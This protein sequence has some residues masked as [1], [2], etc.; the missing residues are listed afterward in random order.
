M[1]ASPD[2]AGTTVA[3]ATLSE[4]DDPVAFRFGLLA[5]IQYTDV[6]DRCNHTGTQ[7]RRYR[8]SLAVARNAVDYFNQSELSFVLHNGDIIDHQCA[9][10]FAKDEFK[11]KAEGIEQLAS[12]MRILSGSLCKDWMFTIGN[13]ELYNFTAA[14]LRDGVT[15]EGCDLPFKCANDEGSFFFSRTPAPGWRVIVL[16]SYDVSIY[17][18]GREQGLDVDALELLRKHNV[19]VDKW[20]TDNPEVIQTE[21]M[22]GTF[23]YFEGLEGLGNRWVP[24]NGGVGEEQ[25]AWLRGQLSEAVAND[26]RVIVFSHLLVHPETTAN[27]SGRTLIWNYQDVLDAVEDERWGKNVAAVVSGHQHEGGLF[28]NDNGTHFVVMESP[29]LAEPGQPGPFCVVEASK[30]GLKMIG[31][32][33]GPNSKIFGVEEGEEYPPSE[34]VVKDLPLAPV[35][36]KA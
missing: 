4:G 13:H 1:P 24:F 3:C 19:N 2:S 15:P 20:V 28:T 27:R 18:K 17:S 29:M 11:P 12:V 5:D 23:P 35:A 36:A 30:S 9:F 32:G 25:L 16:N 31:Y 10:D 8:N 21:R 7:W 33:K 6:D 34:P 26:E 22:S 14:E